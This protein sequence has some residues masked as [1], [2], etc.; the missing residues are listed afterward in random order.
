MDKVN[1][2]ASNFNDMANSLPESVLKPLKNLCKENDLEIGIVP[3]VA[4]FSTGL[5]MTFT[6]GTA[7]F[8]GLITQIYPML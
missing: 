8:F 5:I 4:I 6:C 1:S 3:M 7:L 2:F